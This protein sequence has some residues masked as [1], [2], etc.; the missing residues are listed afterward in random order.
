MLDVLR[1]VAGED[2]DVEQREQDADHTLVLGQ[3]QKRRSEAD[4]SDAGREDGDV[5]VDGKP[6]GN[7][8][9]ELVAR[10]GQ[11]GDSGKGHK[12]AEDDSDKGAR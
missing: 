10:E 12:C 1:D 7:L 11:V 9:L 5:G 3:R 6:I 2:R 8:G 4:F